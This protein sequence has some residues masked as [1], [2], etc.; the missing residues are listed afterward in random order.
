[1]PGA[2]YAINVELVFTQGRIFIVF[3]IA[4]AQF[5]QTYERNERDQ[6]TPDPYFMRAQCFLRILF[7]GNSNAYSLNSSSYQTEAA[8][9]HLS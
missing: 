6:G 5:P 4:S 2:G 3:I 7:R 9:S 8:D 1:M